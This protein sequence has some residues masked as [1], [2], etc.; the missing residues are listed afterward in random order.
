MPVDV[1]VIILTSERFRPL[2]HGR[3]IHESD[4]SPDLEWHRSGIASVRR[5]SVFSACDLGSSLG[6]LRV[7]GGIDHATKGLELVKRFRRRVMVHIAFIVVEHFMKSH[8]PI[9]VN[10]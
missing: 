5:S 6:M 10:S 1:I 4:G 9:Y 8:A 2:D 3:R 7:L